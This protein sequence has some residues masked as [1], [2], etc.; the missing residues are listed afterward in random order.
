MSFLRAHPEYDIIH[1]HL[2]ERS[3]WPL[4]IAERMGIPVRVCHAHN[5]YPFNALDGKSYFRQ[6]F[7]WG[8]GRGKIVTLRLACSSHAGKWLY[9]E[10]TSFEVITNAIDFEQLAFSAS[11]RKR[12]RRELR[13]TDGGKVM[14]FVGRLVKQKNPEYVLRV[15][16][17]LPDRE[18]WRLVLLGKGSERERLQVLARELGIE[19]FVFFGG[20][21]PEVASYYSAFDVLLLP[22][23]YEGLG[24]VTVEAGANGLPVVASNGVPEEANVV[25]NTTFVDLGDIQRWVEIA[26]RE[27]LRSMGNSRNVKMTKAM[28]EYD[29]NEAVERLERMYEGLTY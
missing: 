3:Y 14:G 8:L 20:E 4:K 7:R 19:K 6:W 29:I 13:I 15:F 10:K 21:V 24:M 1:S 16:A 26:E 12:L 17:A 11:D 5:V 28:R 27:A 23:L 25:K 2:E 18:E 22:S 9:G